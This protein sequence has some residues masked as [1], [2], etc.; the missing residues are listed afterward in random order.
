MVPETP[1]GVYDSPTMMLT[2]CSLSLDEDDDLHD[3]LIARIHKYKGF[4]FDPALHNPEKSVG[5]L[6]DHTLLKSTDS[7]TY[8]GHEFEH[9]KFPMTAWVEVSLGAEV[10]EVE[11]TSYGYE[12]MSGLAEGEQPPVLHNPN[13]NPGLSYS[14]DHPDSRLNYDGV[15]YQ[16]IEPG[17]IATIGHVH[18]RR[19]GEPEGLWDAMLRYLKDDMLPKFPS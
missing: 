6:L 7:T 13:M 1:Y 11:V 12:Y 5:S 4:D 2:M 15:K 19:E 16:D 9:R 18:G 10:C 3:D 17:E 14:A 8:T